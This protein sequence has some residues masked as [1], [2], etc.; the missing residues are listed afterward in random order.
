MTFMS[1]MTSMTS[2]TF[3]EFQRAVS[4]SCQSGKGV[5]AEIRKEQSRNNSVALGQAPVS[6]SRKY[7]GIFEFFCRT[8]TPN[9]WKVLWSILHSRKKDH[10][11]QSRGPLSTNSKKEYKIPSILILICGPIFQS[12]NHNTMSHSL[13]KKGTIFKAL[14]CCVLLCLAKQ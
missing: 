11:N 9:K 3:P 12:Q 5:Y 6:S 4:S 8:K 10:Q 7:N 14:A 1:F 2:V 13:P